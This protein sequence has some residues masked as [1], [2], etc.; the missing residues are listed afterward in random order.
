MTFVFV[1]LFCY[2]DLLFYFRTSEA[3]LSGL[4]KLEDLN[5]S[6][7]LLTSFTVPALPALKKVLLTYNSLTMLKVEA[8]PKLGMALSYVC[9]VISC[10]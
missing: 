2:D 5:L 7:N 3:S 10:I 9:F 6:H 1:I 4:A 8:C